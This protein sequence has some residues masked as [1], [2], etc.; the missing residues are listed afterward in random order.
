MSKKIRCA[1]CFHCCNLQIADTGELINNCEL[2]LIGTGEY[3]YIYATLL[4]FS[5]DTYFEDKKA[6]IIKIKR[7]LKMNDK[8]LMLALLAGKKMKAKNGDDYIFLNEEGNIEN[9]K[10]KF[11][12]KYLV[13]NTSDYEEYIDI[14]PFVRCI[15]CKFCIDLKISD[16]GDLVNHC[17]IEGEKQEYYYESLVQDICGEYNEIMNKAKVEYKS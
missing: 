1:D 5:C 4:K 10:H 7:R 11:L 3:R 14:Q 17:K 2:D 8:E 16:N 6:N 13:D 12:K 15:D 9:S